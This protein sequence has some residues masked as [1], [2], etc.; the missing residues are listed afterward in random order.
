MDLERKK[1]LAPICAAACVDEAQKLLQKPHRRRWWR[2]PA[3]QRRLG[4]FGNLLPH[5]RLNDPEMYFKYLRMSPE[6]YTHL[7]SLVS[8]KLTKVALRECV[9]ASERLTIT[10]VYLATGCSQQDLSFRSVM[11]YKIH[12][13]YCILHC[14]RGTSKSHKLKMN[15]R[16]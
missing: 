16:I 13:M 10:L 8:D 6:W 11:F 3:Y 9:S 5:L 7:L 1:V 2:R 14:R 15:Q 4:E 12:V